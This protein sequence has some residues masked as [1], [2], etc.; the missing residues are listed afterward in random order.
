V[1]LGAEVRREL[2]QPRHVFAVEETVELADFP[3]DRPWPEPTDRCDVAFVPRGANGDWS[4][5][6][7]EWLAAP[8]R[9][10]AV[11]AVEVAE[12]DDKVRWRPGRAVVQARP[13]RRADVLAAL[14]EFAF[15]E[16]ELRAL[17][18]AVEAHEAQAQQDSA[19]AH[20]VRQRDRKNWPRVAA[21]IEQLTRLRLDHA[22]LAP[23]LAKG[24]RA[25]PPEARRLVTRLLRKADASARLA[26][27][28]D[29][30]E[31][32]EDLYEGAN[33]R[34]ADY[35][36]YRNGHRIEVL[37]VVLLV[38]EAVVMSFELYLHHLDRRDSKA[39]EAAVATQDLSI[40]FPATIMRV[41][42][43][44]VRFYKEDNK[45]DEQTL[46]VADNVKVFD[47]NDKEIGR[48]LKNDVFARIGDKGLKALLVT[49]AENKK[50]AE[51]YLLTAVRRA[52]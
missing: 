30:L 40:E 46:P 10:D 8:P 21:T 7:D 38:I 4:R 12:G 44:K 45:N 15:Y 36:W 41:A 52:P 16:A 33:D 22:R 28:G 27:V 48:G 43:G 2:T 6:A 19:I 5:A 39:A 20:K 11:P 51:I 14:A 35:R 24:S 17:E 37:I 26:A 3:A 29:R 25:L 1:P 18:A 31:A 9:P 34:V 42:D 50:V 47:K 32:L 23:R 49:D 13:D